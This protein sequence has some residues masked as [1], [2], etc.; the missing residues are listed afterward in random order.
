MILLKIKIMLIIYSE[1][2]TRTGVG[3]SY[4]FSKEN[5]NYM[6]HSEEDE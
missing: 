4:T 6:S 1:G 3:S 5:E 2:D